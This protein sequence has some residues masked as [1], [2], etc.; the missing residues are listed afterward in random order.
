MKQHE[1][2]PERLCDAPTLGVALARLRDGRDESLCANA[3]DVDVQTWRTWEQG[4]AFPDEKQ[5]EDVLKTLGK[6][7]DALYLEIAS[8]QRQRMGF[9]PN[10]DL[11][12][13]KGEATTE[14]ILQILV[15]SLEMCS[16]TLADLT[17]LA[18]LGLET[19]RRRQ[20]DEAQRLAESELERRGDGEAERD[21]LPTIAVDSDFEALY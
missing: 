6:K 5:L 21:E 19:S 7:P 2:E 11:P 8:I 20:V 17:S 16:C 15:F 18:R 9:E 1:A 14:E 4:R 13:L 12:D 10:V 3:V